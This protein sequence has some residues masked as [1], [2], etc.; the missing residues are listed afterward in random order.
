MH[1]DY[2]IL[3]SAFKH[4]IT[5]Q[6]IDYALSDKNPTRRFYEMHDDKD[7]NAQDMVIAHTGTRPWA[8][9]IGLCYLTNENVVFH[10]SKISSEFKKQYEVER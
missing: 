8:V 5:E 4:G 10:A 1:K 6:E 9:E 7:G 2:R 3:K